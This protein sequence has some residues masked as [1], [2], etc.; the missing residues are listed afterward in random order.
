VTL[1]A[2][3]LTNQTSTIPVVACGPGAFYSVGYYSVLPPSGGF[4][5]Y[6]A[7]SVDWTTGKPTTNPNAF[8]INQTAFDPA[9]L[10][11]IALSATCNTDALGVQDLFAGWENYSL[12]FYKY[13]IP[14]APYNFRQ[15]STTAVSTVSAGSEWEVYP[16]P[17]SD[18]ITLTAPSGFTTN[19]GATYHIADLS[20][21]TLLENTIS[22]TNQ[23]INISS[24]PAGMYM[25]NIH[26]DETNTKTIKFVKE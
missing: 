22:N 18:L 16:N 15:A 14:V 11:G 23:E 19:E 9:F 5:D 20:G 7:T 6:F 13:S 17:G 3:G 4:Q 24:L 21:K 26:S 25:L 2:P 1:P 10:P 12:L 8:Q